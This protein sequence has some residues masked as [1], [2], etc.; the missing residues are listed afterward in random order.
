MRKA[1]SKKEPKTVWQKQTAR[2]NGSGQ[3]KQPGGVLILKGLGK[4][5]RK[6][7]TPTES[8]KP[9]KGEPGALLVWKSG[10][11]CNWI[12]LW[13]RRRAGIWLELGRPF[14]LLVLRLWRGWWEL[15][16]METSGKQLYIILIR[17][18]DAPWDFKVPWAKTSFKTHVKKFKATNI[19]AMT[20]MVLKTVRSASFQ[21]WIGVLSV[22]TLS[23]W[24]RI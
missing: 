17:D 9:R 16:R 15:A 8:R 23:S 21:A 24:S 3:V 20:M 5:K 22:G 7:I 6:K 11:W 2:V 14:F 19:I 4:K 13:C 1:V 12:L 10:N 18:Q